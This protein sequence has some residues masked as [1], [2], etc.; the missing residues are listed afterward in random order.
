MIFL[1]CM[2]DYHDNHCIQR[3]LPAGKYMVFSELVVRSSVFPPCRAHGTGKSDADF[4]PRRDWHPQ[5][6][7]HSCPSRVSNPREK[8]LLECPR[9][10]TKIE[11]ELDESYAC[12]D[13][14]WH[15]HT[16][17]YPSSGPRYDTDIL[18]TMPHWQLFCDQIGS[19]A[20]SLLAR[21]S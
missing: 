14:A 5:Q 8:Q 11:C 15:W 18:A 1:R 13:C 7:S 17:S 12:E 21:P 16:S 20:K 4:A 9:A 19:N 10:C 3:C 6:T 2:I